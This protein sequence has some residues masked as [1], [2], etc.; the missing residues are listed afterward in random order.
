MIGEYLPITIHLPPLLQNQQYF[1]FDS[2]KTLVFQE[3]GKEKYRPI[4][5]RCDMRG[6]APWNKGIQSNIPDSTIDFVV[7]NYRIFDDENH[8]ISKVFNLERMGEQFQ[9][10]KYQTHCLMDIE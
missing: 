8:I 2:L 9:T 10:V 5:A 6:N 3:L 4:L 7:L 1:K